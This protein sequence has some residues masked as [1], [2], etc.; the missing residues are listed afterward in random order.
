MKPSRGI[1]K[2]STLLGV[3]NLLKNSLKQTGVPSTYTEVKQP[4]IPETFEGEIRVL[5]IFTKN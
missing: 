1:D 3:S 5:K 2:T 4:K